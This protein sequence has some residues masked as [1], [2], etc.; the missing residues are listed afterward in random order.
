MSK[1]ILISINPFPAL[2]ILNGNKTL[3][4]RKSIPKDFKGW[5]YLYVA[6]AKPLLTYDK[7]DWDSGWVLY[8]NKDEY[9]SDHAFSVNGKVVARFWFDE[10]DEYVDVSNCGMT[11]CGMECDNEFTYKLYD[12][13]DELEK[14][15]LSYNEVYYYGRGKDLYAWHI[16]QLEIFDA[17]KELKDFVVCNKGDKCNVEDNWTALTKAPQ[18]WQYVWAKEET[19]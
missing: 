5:V 9:Y 12:L 3:E 18:S 16:K 11:S 7:F 14:L 17:P 1:S 19:Q 6:K 10:Y 8:D 15:C 4:L 13:D 2:T